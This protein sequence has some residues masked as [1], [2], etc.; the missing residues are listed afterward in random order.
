ME[1]TNPLHIVWGYRWWLL[2]FAS[3]AAAVVFGLS[4]LQAEQYQ[5]TAVVQ[6]VS[7]RAQSNEFVSADELFQQANFYASLARTRPVQEATATALEPDA[8]DP[9]L[10]A[11]PVSGWRWPNIFSRPAAW[12]RCGR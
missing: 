6:V 1:S 11:G 12:R 3:V 5:A 7:G 8:E 10:P 4:S 9:T 2:A